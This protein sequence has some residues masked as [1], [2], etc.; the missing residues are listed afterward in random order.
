MRVR[1]GGGRPVMVRGPVTGAGYRF[2]AA[3][4]VQLVDP[5]DA[6]AI[7]RNSLFRV[8]SAVELTGV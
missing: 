7:V 8:E 3:E 4:R 6:V 2:S 5:R 1:Y